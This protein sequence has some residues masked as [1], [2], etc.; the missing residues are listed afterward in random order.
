VRERLTIDCPALEAQIVDIS[1]L[2]PSGAVVYQNRLRI[3]SGGLSIPVGSWPSGTY[4]VQIRAGDK[5]A[6][7]RFLKI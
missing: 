3:D 7:G 1:V 5:R 4:S 6:A 2:A